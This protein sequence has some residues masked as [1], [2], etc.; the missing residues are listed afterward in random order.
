MGQ[1][2]QQAR[3][4]PTPRE[5]GTP[6]ARRAHRIDLLV[7]ARVFE[8]FRCPELI[9]GPTRRVGRNIAGLAIHPLGEVSEHH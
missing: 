7:L 2:S 6:Q 9:G 4:P 1:A 3:G 5:N 8:K